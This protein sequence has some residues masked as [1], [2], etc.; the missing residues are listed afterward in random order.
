[1]ADWQDVMGAQWDKIVA[2]DDVSVFV[3]YYPG[4]DDRRFD[5]HGFIAVMDG[6]EVDDRPVPFIVYCYVKHLQR[7]LGIASGMLAYAGIDPS[8][9]FHFAAKT[10][11]IT[12]LKK[13]LPLA[14]WKPIAIRYPKESK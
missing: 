2:R 11:V 8:K 12:K 4:E 5:L 1:M 7:R 14:R 9:P 3:A 6:Y 10:S 13:V